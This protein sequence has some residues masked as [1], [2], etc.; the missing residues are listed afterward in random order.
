MSE[1]RPVPDRPPRR[2]IAVALS[3]AVVVALLALFLSQ[4]NLNPTYSAIALVG[5]PAPTFDLPSATSGRVQS[6]ALTGKA[7]IINFWNTWCPPCVQEAPAVARFYAAHATDTDFA[8]VG[9]V[10]DDATSAVRRWVKTRGVG[11]LVAMDPGETAAVDFGTT[12]QPETYAVSPEGFVVA[13]Q[14]GAAST[15]DLEH[16]LA[17]ARGQA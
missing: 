11:W 13:K 10:R 7:V 15:A 5:R 8:M 3:G 16:L 14:L 9:I 6:V 1:P 2:R 12:G 4:L 17:L